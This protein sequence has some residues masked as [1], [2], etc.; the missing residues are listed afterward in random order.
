MATYPNTLDTHGITPRGVG[1][2]VYYKPTGRQVSLK[3]NRWQGVGIECRAE[4]SRAR[5]RLVSQGDS[6]S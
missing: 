6:H 1:N 2:A 4:Q 3:H 5:L